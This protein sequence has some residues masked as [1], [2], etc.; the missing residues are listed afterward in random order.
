MFLRKMPGCRGVLCLFDGPCLEQK[1]KEGLIQQF[2][3]A[4]FKS[5]HLEDFY[6]MRACKFHCTSKNA[7][8]S[9]KDTSL[10]GG[11]TQSKKRKSK[12]IQRLETAAE[13]QNAKK[14]K[15]DRISSTHPAHTSNVLALDCEMVE[16]T[17]D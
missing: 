14:Q 4:L 3:P 2:G 12:R 7:T 5:K 11:E 13:Q 16:V 1:T 15:V 8:Q 10:K 9:S 17:I 6:S